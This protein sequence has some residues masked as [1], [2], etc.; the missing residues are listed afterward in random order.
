MEKTLLHRSDCPVSCSLDIFGDK[1]SLLIVRDLIHQGP[2]TYGD[3][4][5]APE[6]IASNILANRLADLTAS[7]IISKTAYPG[8]KAKYLYKLTRMGIDLAPVLMELYKWRSKYFPVTSEYSEMIE[9]IK[10][11]REAFIRKLHAHLEE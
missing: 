6:K 7:G 3:F 10:K 4:L 5:K 8:S 1:W 9:A 11:D 2:R